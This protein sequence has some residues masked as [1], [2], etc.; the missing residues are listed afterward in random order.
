MAPM[1]SGLDEGL[2][3]SEAVPVLVAVESETDAFPVGEQ[4]QVW[5][6]EALK[7]RDTEL[8]AFL[9]KV[10][11]DVEESCRTLLAILATT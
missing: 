4:R 6:A 5:S 3:D 2:R 11:K 8:E 7:E 1:L 10:R 9:S